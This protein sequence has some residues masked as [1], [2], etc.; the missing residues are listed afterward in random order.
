MS[1][2]YIP[3]AA[4]GVE[5]WDTFYTRLKNFPPQDRMKIMG[6]YIHAKY[7][8]NYDNQRRISGERKFEHPRHTALILIDELHITN[9]AIICAAFLHETK[10][11]T[12]IFGNPKK[13]TPPDYEEF[14]SAFIAHIF[15]PQT[16]E[17]V[18][19]LTEPY[20][21]GVVIT[22]DYHAKQ[23]KYERLR[24][25]SEEAILVKMA[26]RLQSLRTFYIKEGQLTPE[27]RIRETEDVLMPIF[28]RAA[29]KYPEETAY[30]ISE[31]KKAIQK[32]RERSFTQK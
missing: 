13:M 3:E 4:T 12:A 26:D 14:S 25:A 5:N 20:V 11:D 23:V 2:K 10:E 15:Y 21:D 24:S 1:E 27:E 22:S 29:Q 8:H 30:L 31:I 28:E 18:T 16:A 9:P 32:L 7:A 17:I 19:A 6:S